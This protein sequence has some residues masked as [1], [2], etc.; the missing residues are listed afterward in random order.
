M[1]I[2]FIGP[3]GAGKSTQA[4]RLARSLPHWNTSP[5]LSTGELVRAQIEAGTDL[6]RELEER[7]ERGERVPNETILSLVLPRVRRSGGWILDN[8][9][10]DVAQAK[11]LDEEIE[12]RGAGGI[13]RVIS[14]E[15]PSEEELIRRVLGG[16]VTSRATGEVYHLQNDPPPEERERQDPGP[17]EKR[18]DDTEESLKRN[19]VAYRREAAA[20][21]EYYEARGVLS[22][23]DARRSMDEVA[24]EVLEALGH[25]E[26]SEF[27]AALRK[28]KTA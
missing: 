1:R 23:V 3:P 22:V 16:R 25:P 24:E 4:K 11:A 2:A 13:S 7:Y 5:R 14:L 28:S 26:R 20:L 19:M 18:G 27:Y 12:E 8:F 17:F 6:G 21:K 9:P 10:A 15:G